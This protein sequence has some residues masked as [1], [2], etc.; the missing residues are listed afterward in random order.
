[1]YYREDGFMSSGT[2]RNGNLVWCSPAAFQRNKINMVMQNIRSRS[3]KEGF[4]Y[5]VDRAYLESI[6]P[7]DFICPVSK[8]KMEWGNNSGRDNSPSLDRIQPELG[9]VK[10][11][12]VWVSNRVN[13][14]KHNASVEL[15]RQIVDFY[16][17]ISNG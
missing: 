13:R 14:I 5:N 1:M 12:V 15:L 8:V 17:N 9:Y 6:F 7:D 11:N 10:G 4:V 2:R 16:S 3:L